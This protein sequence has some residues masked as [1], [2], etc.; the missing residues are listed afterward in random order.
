MEEA[1]SIALEHVIAEIRRVTAK[2]P[3]ADLPMLIGAL[4]QF[5]AQ[6]QLRMLTGER[7]SGDLLTV[8]HVAQ[9]LKLSAYRVY[10]LVRQGHL[11]AVRLGKSV[12][13][14][15]SAVTDYLAKLAA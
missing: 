10:E 13:I 15:P 12:R 5:Q 2:T 8:P 3:V 14:H 6:A 1:S 11:K 4:A 9:Q 7:V